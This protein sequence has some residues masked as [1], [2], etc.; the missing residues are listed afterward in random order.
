MHGAPATE[1]VIELFQ[2]LKA[3]G[4]HLFLLSN[5]DEERISEFNQHLAVPYI[6]IS[7]KTQS[8]K[9]HKSS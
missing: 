4:F 1:Q 2:K 6:P 9:L 5:N 7:E 8:K 3:L